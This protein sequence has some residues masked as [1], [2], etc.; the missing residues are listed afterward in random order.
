VFLFLLA[1]DL[2]INSFPAAL[3]FSAYFTLLRRRHVVPSS[4]SSALVEDA[5][6][7]LTDGDTGRGA[8]VAQRGRKGRYILIH[9][10][11]YICLHMLVFVYV[12]FT[13]FHQT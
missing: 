9:S 13:K 4:S 1:C 5:M 11:A 6:N 12:S 7:T 2:P 10:H 3:G 8:R